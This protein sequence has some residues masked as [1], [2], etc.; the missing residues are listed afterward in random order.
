[1]L[2]SVLSTVTVLA[3]LASGRRGAKRRTNKKPLAR[4]ARL[5]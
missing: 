3:C 5:L 1:V 4:C 2:G